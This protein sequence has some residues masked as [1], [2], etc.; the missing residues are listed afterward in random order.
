M[1]LFPSLNGKTSQQNEGTAPSQMLKPNK[2]FD[3]RYSEVLMDSIN[4]LSFN[5]RIIQE[6]FQPKIGRKL[7][8]FSLGRKNNILT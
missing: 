5:L 4:I 1:K 2:Q 3:E 8:I 6:T 7:R